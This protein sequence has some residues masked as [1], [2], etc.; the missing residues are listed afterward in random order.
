MTK[1]E[2]TTRA[3]DPLEYVWLS[4]SHVPEPSRVEL[5]LS[6]SLAEVIKPT[7]WRAPAKMAAASLISS[8]SVVQL[9]CA[10]A[11]K[12]EVR[13]DNSGLMVVAGFASIVALECLIMLA[14]FKAFEMYVKDL[15]Y[16]KAMRCGVMI[17][18]K[19]AKFAGY[20]NSG[21][22]L[23]TI[24]FVSATVFIFNGASSGTTGGLQYLNSVITLI[25]V[26]AGIYR[27]LEPYVQCDLFE[28]TLIALPKFIENDPKAARDVISKCVVVP[29]RDIYARLCDLRLVQGLFVLEALVDY[30]KAHGYDTVRAYSIM[31]QIQNNDSLTSDE[32]Q[33]QLEE[34]KKLTN[35]TRKQHAISLNQLI[36][37]DDESGASVK[38]AIVGRCHATHMTYRYLF[39]KEELKVEDGKY[40][41]ND[42]NTS[43]NFRC[44]LLGRYVS[45]MQSMTE[46]MWVDDE[47]NATFNKDWSR[48]WFG[49]F[50]Q[51]YSMTG[52]FLTGAGFLFGSIY[53]LF[54]FASASN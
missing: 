43:T 34:V 27:L 53:Y 52:Y 13:A 1:V 15:L 42:F 20:K 10:T 36:V 28:N 54:S 49:S 4:G 46:V 32:R 3:G 47:L 9:A 22:V 6:T 39:P 33:R 37:Q 48:S 38:G 14:S 8:L 11:F 16:Y 30:A 35:D 5:E 45:L 29:E 21:T 24:L 44:A 17:D 50:F 7:S 2:R 41:Y 31:H 40:V 19:N 25:L 23:A 51:M 26:A 12:A 18:Y